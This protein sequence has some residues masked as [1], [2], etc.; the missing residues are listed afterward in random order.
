MTQPPH[1]R[2]SESLA[3]HRENSLVERLM[4]ANHR[5]A[6]LE[7]IERSLS[8]E[9]DK[10]SAIVSTELESVIFQQ[11]DAELWPASRL[12]RLVA[13]LTLPQRRD[14]WLTT[15]TRL[16]LGGSI[17]TLYPHDGKDLDPLTILVRGSGGFGDM[18]YLSLVVRLLFLRFDR[19]R[20]VVLHEHPDAH[21]IFSNNPYVV[22]AISLRGEQHREFLQVTAALDIFDL[23][24]DVRY[25]VSY[26]AP[27]RS[28]I[29]F[30]FLTTAHSRA[31][32]WQR[33]VRRDW[34]YLNNILAN[35]AVGRGMSKY[36][37]LGY[38]GNLPASSL[39]AGDFFPSERVSSDIL[40]KLNCRYVTIHHGADRFMSGLDG[41]STKN[42]PDST[43]ANVVTRCKAAGLLTI[44]L[45]EAREPLI[46][47]V[48][49]D[50]R[51]RTSFSQT[52]TVLKYASAHL[53]TEGGLVHLA[54][55]M[56]T[57][58]IV[59]FGPTPVGFFGYSG[60][61][62]IP[63]KECGNCW[64]VSQNWARTCPKGM[65]KPICMT[66]HLGSEMANA[67]IG[68][69]K[70]PKS[71]IINSANLQLSNLETAIKS[72]APPLMDSGL[73][74]G[75]VVLD[76]REDVDVLLPH[77]IGQRLHFRMAVRDQLFRDV[78]EAT[79]FLD[80]LPFTAGHIP[81][82]TSACYWAIISLKETESEV[83]T[84]L[85]CDTI[86][87]LKPGS[88]A[89][90]LGSPDDID[91]EA[92]RLSIQIGHMIGNKVV[93]TVGPSSAVSANQDGNSTC[94]MLRILQPSLTKDEEVANC[95][96]VNAGG[97]FAPPS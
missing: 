83:R 93:A 60:N 36:E 35:E 17:A 73:H 37:L 14:A 15:I 70:G 52:A 23:I 55:S 40:S 26:T 27:P 43:W 45:G 96:L 95:T 68:V 7:K 20:I 3:R 29:P 81:T 53:D 67:A 11:D 13:S 54:R 49:V 71:V 8:L 92:K 38:T 58:A 4:Q 57:T 74:H 66:S 82:N 34:P 48:D 87:V 84:Q 76:N 10:L 46:D 88:V 61:V 1:N 78:A 31:A 75:L 9:R 24:A 2:D 65:A 16:G 5:I 77:L 63:P 18:L 86:R 47:N 50:L 51:G 28:R 69:A 79:T 59:A 72:N 12:D 90:L 33:F 85:I 94:L 25:V 21:Q 30:E 41:L 42:L 80:I 97:A 62:N 39:D 89:Y 32:E 56:G 22:A 64:W 6:E 91:E 19:P 44:Q